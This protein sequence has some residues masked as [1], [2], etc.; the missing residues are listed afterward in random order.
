VAETS[1]T[2]TSPSIIDA[3][4]AVEWRD[5]ATTAEIIQCELKAAGEPIDVPITDTGEIALAPKEFPLAVVG[6]TKHLGE[7]TERFP[8]G[9][10]PIELFCEAPTTTPRVSVTAV[11]LL[12]WSTG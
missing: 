2:L 7:A 6:S 8:A 12:A 11:N 4:A 10:H 5:E 3:S 1:I 9:A